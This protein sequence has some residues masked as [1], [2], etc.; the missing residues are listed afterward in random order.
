MLGYDLVCVRESSA[1]GRLSNTVPQK[2]G[3]RG[4]GRRGNQA[5]GELL[6]GYGIQ[7]VL[8]ALM[9][10]G[11]DDEIWV[12]CRAGKQDEQGG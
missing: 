8:G 7:E 10:L 3:D 9:V 12:R 4:Q 11:E 6:A 1:I 5:A 2:N